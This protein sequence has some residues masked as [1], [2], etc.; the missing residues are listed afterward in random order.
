[1]DTG[2]ILDCKAKKPD[3][4][5]SVSPNWNAATASCFPTSN[6]WKRCYIINK[7]LVYCLIDGVQSVAEL[8]AESESELCSVLKKKIKEQFPTDAEEIEIITV[9]K[10]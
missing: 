6:A 8:E 2:A 10:I 9:E 5:G 4:C 1:M 3:Y 7:Y